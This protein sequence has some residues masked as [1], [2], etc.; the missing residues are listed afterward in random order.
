[1]RNMFLMAACASILLVS[2]GKDG[3]EGKKEEPV[4][5]NTWP[6][7]GFSGNNYWYL[8]NGTVQIGVDLSRGGC[9]FHFS[10]KGTKRNL[11][12]HYD[13]GRF[14]QQSYYD[15]KTDGS[16]WNGK[17]WRWN[18]IQGGG[19]KEGTGAKILK[20]EKSETSI[21]IQ[22]QPVHWASCEA[23]P[24]CDMTEIIT[25]GENYAKI[26]YKFTNNGTGSYS[27]AQ[28]D[29]EL[30]AVF[31]DGAL[32]T[33][34]TYEGDAPWTGDD[35]TYVKNV[36]SV[37]DWPF[38]Q[39]LSSECWAAYLDSKGWGI[40]VYTP[41][42]TGTP[43]EDEAANIG[44]VRYS[45]YRAS[46]SNYPG[47]GPVG[48]SCSYFGPHAKKTIVKGFSLEYDVYLAIGTAEEIRSTFK[49]IHDKKL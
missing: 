25:L 36:T 12:N 22:T 27:H 45:A 15:G 2:C 47:T 14:I 43:G 9:V 39:A 18:P 20:R 4:V 10:E 16:V 26:H 31:C 38:T 28:Y 7:S 8:S 3:G 41:Q 37:T 32:G 13:N 6:E 40:G 23:L 34:V 29:Q 1:M 49:N 24:E 44:K 35:L 11:I 42:S 30:P 5:Q 48:A 19:W 46:G 21:E 33:F 17:N